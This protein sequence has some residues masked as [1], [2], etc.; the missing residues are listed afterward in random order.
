M[1]RNS[2]LYDSC[3]NIKREPMSH[4]A[5]ENIAREIG[6]NYRTIPTF[7]KGLFEHQFIRHYSL[8]RNQQLK[9]RWS[10]YKQNIEGR[11]FA[12]FQFPN[13]RDLHFYQSAIRFA[14]SESIYRY[15][16]H[17]MKLKPGPGVDFRGQMPIPQ[18][19]H[20]KRGKIEKSDSHRQ[21]IKSAKK[22]VTGAKT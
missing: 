17:R 6:N 22:K 4:V 18:E 21:K 19:M 12:P 14:P 2:S 11:V 7:E 15:P 5:D 13:H 8:Q 10:V 9:C 16:E 20:M 1:A 3:K